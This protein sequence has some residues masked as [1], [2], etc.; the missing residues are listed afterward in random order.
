MAMSR[1]GEP[2]GASWRELWRATTER[3]DDRVQARWLLQEASR[4][5]APAL[6][7]ALDEEASP[8]EA[9]HLESLVQRRLAGEPLQ[10]V[11]GHWGFR[12]LD[13]AVDSRVLAP[14]PETESV[15]G[16]AL[17]ELD[18]LRKLR[19]ASEGLLAVD[20]GTGSGV[21]ALSLVAE[22]PAVRVIATDRD[23]SALAVASANRSRLSIPA[24]G[25]V[26]YL[27]GD[28]Y[29]GLPTELLGRFDLIVAN[30]PYL[31]E[32][33]WAGLDPVVRDFDPFQALVAGP[34]G[35]EAIGVIVAGAPRWL[36]RRGTAVVEIAPDQT[37]SAVE[38]ARKAGFGDVEVEPDL[39]GRPRVLI[40]RL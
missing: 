20:L 31:A 4:S 27:Q 34:S 16:F 12:T 38:L 5:D 2:A 23:P 33:E 17:S 36:H 26:E 21:I 13:V 30:P 15:V 8:E 6:L 10:H 25:R 37:R 1:Q 24:A 39:S 19:A 22:E 40:A 14:R 28:W 9:A 3:I 35:L 11:L 7:R 18:Q 32:H 29:Q